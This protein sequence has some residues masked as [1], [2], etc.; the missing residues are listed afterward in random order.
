M[1]YRAILVVA[2]VMLSLSVP[3]VMAQ[4]DPE[5]QQ[6]VYVGGT[7][8]VEPLSTFAFNWSWWGLDEGISLSFYYTTNDQSH[9]VYCSVNN[10]KYNLLETYDYF[11]LHTWNRTDFPARAELWWF[12]FTN[13]ANTTVSLEVAVTYD[14]PEPE[15]GVNYLQV[16]LILGVSTWAGTIVILGVGYYIRARRERAELD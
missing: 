14:I 11:Y 9:P 5:P 15:E 7:V 1:K 16:L 8:D 10:T 6:L 12:T 13:I 2:L 3:L 4:E